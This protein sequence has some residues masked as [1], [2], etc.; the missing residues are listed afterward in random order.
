[1]IRPRFPAIKPLAEVIRHTPM[2]DFDGYRTRRPSL[3]AMRLQQ[4]KQLYLKL[5]GS[6]P[7]NFDEMVGVNFGKWQERR[8]RKCKHFQAFATPQLP[9]SA[10][11]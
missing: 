9:K 7:I 1:M 5:P 3:Q 11:S 10:R 8:P 2:C 4:S 6:G